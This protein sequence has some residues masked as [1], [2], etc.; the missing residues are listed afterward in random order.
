M[1]KLSIIIPAYNAEPHIKRCIDSI[2]PILS[3]EI[4]AIVVDDGSTDKTLSILQSISF[5]TPHLRY[6]H[7]ENQGQSVARNVGLTLALGEYIWFLDSDDY[8]DCSCFQPIME[9]IDTHKNDLIVIGRIDEMGT[10]QKQTQKLWNATYQTGVEYF[11]HTIRRGVYRTQPWDKIVKRRLL[12]ENNINFE[13]HR[14][15]EDMLHGLQIILKAQTTQLIALY[16]YHYVLYN[17]NSLTKQIRKNDLDAIYFT[18]KAF[19]MLRDRSQPTDGAYLT[20]VFSFLSS[21][22]LKKYIP[23]TSQNAEAQMMVDT[24][25]KNTLFKKATKYCATHYV[26]FSRTIMATLICISPRLYQHA[27]RWALKFT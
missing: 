26:G 12:I 4:E 9:V 13:P 21:C 14:M 8:I 20:L 1:I 24:V 27:V 3:P 7:Q 18:D 5:T 17:P 10:K 6:I 23:L 2:T 11:Q 25:I 22:I 16:P 15:F 19:Q